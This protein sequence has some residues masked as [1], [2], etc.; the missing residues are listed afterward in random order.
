MIMFINI[1]HLRKIRMGSPIFSPEVGTWVRINTRP[2]LVVSPL[3][4]S[5]QYDVARDLVDIVMDRI[6]TSHY[7]NNGEM[8]DPDWDSTLVKM[9]DFISR[10]Y[11]GDLRE[12]LIDYVG[13]RISVL[14][15]LMVHL[16]PS[17]KVEQF[18]IENRRIPWEWVS[19][20]GS[21]I[22]LYE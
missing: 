20:S 5:S 16:G 18:A 3:K 7:L 21:R 2:P 11:Q 13:G 17:E 14:E 15:G 9:G 19:L 6:I 12:D 10:R 22:R 1:K 8:S 4:C